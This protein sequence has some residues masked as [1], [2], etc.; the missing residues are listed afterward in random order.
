LKEKQGT[1]ISDGMDCVFPVG[2]IDSCNFAEVATGLEV[3]LERPF[4]SRWE[5]R[6]RESGM[7]NRVAM[8]SCCVDCAEPS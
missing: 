6:L 1:C 4:R 5:S 3:L 2:G 8:S 7:S